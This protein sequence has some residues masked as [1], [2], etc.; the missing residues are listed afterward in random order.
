M[1]YRSALRPLLFSLDPEEAH[2][3]TLGLLGAANSAPLR[4]GGRAFT[5]AALTVSL[6]GLTFPNPVGLAAG[7]DKNGRAAAIWPRFGF[8]FVEVGTVTAQPQAGNPK[9]R[10][11]RLPQQEALINR[12]GFNSEGAEVVARRL[13]ALR[14]RPRAMPVPLG[15]N[16]GKTKKVSGDAAT[17]DDYR[18]SFRRLSRLADFIV[19]NVSSPNTPGLRQWQERDKLES[20]LGALVE[21]QK[22]LARLR[23]CKPV[24]IFVKVSPDMDEVDLRDAADVAQELGLAGIVATNTT[25]AREGALAGVEQQGGLSGKPLRERACQTLRLLYRHTQGRIPLIGVG[26]IACAEDAYARI[27]AGASLVQFYTA[28]VYEGPFL[29]RQINQ[30][31]LRLMARD[32]VKQVA[33]LVGTEP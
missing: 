29:P 1:F 10:V 4:V 6:A 22:A 27:K 13:A 9:P 26:G 5:N 19:V 24:P 33:E 28:L 18:L 14:R 17:L 7:C 20:L 11:F 15:I 12:L 31:L 3:R 2:E 8:G 25:L 23:E 21:E 32:G 16:I 30:G